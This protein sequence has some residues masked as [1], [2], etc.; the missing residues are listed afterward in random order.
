M[1][2]FENEE[3]AMRE[4]RACG[5]ALSIVLLLG[6]ACAESDGENSA[7][8]TANA[9][10]TAGAPI[11]AAAETDSDI[12]TAGESG[13]AT[14]RNLTKEPLFL[15]GCSPFVF[16]QSLDG[17]WE[18]VG[19]PFVCVW[20]GFAV[21][22]GEDERDETWFVAPNES[23]FYR[24]RYD[25]SLGCEPDL[26]LSQ[27]NC[28]SEAVVYSNEFEVER[29]LCEPTQFGC[30]FV[31]A[32]PNFLCPDGVNISGPSEECTRDPASGVCG[33]EFLSCP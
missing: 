21:A 33:Y 12:Y 31:P 26:P 24:L 6:V 17:L 30:R 29:E 25:Y 4:F 32:A 27:A 2:S 13:L 10:G 23:G 5:R 8:A 15:P 18:F 11:P 3:A 22:I 19:P 28:A 16:E 7:A 20:E 14:F 9:A 1:F